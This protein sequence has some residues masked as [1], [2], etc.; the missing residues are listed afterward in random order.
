MEKYGVVTEEPKNEK[1]S[2]DNTICPV[3]HKPIRHFH[4]KGLPYCMSC[5]TEPFEKRGKS[6]QRDER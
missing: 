1:T 2:G 4:E 3:C 6:D 5:G